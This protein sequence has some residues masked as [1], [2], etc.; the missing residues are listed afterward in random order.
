MGAVNL[1]QVNNPQMPKGV[2]QEIPLDIVIHGVSRELS[3]KR[4]AKRRL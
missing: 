4:S 3:G 1:F 2:E